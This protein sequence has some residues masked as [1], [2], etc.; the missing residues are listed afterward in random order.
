MITRINWIGGE[1]RR[2]LQVSRIVWTGEFNCGSSST[3]EAHSTL[4]ATLEERVLRAPVLGIIH[5]PPQ[6]PNT[7]TQSLREPPESQLPT[8]SEARVLFHTHP[9][10]LLSTPRTPFQHNRILP[11]P[12]RT[13]R[14]RSPF[15]DFTPSSS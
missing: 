7:Q 15:F 6:N 10:S 5:P 14:T 9:S 11:P 1:K 12:Y 3:E 4:R 13:P 8:T 2:R